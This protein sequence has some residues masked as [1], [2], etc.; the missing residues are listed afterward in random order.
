MK[1][2]KWSEP[3]R[4]ELVVAILIAIVSLTTA[5]ATWRTASVGSNAVS[6]NHRGLISAVKKEAAMNEDWRQAYQEAGYARDWA[7]ALTGIQALENS[8]DV[9]AIERAGVMRQFLL[10]GLASLAGPFA[11]D[12][13]YRKADG[14]FDVEKRFNSLEAESP[15][16]SSLD[17]Q[18]SFKQAANYF[19]EQRWLVIGTVLMAISL[20]WLGV[21]QIARPRLRPLA[22]LAGVGIYVFGAAWFILVEVVFL[23]IRKGSL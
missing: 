16:L 1:K 19:N 21:A 22:R 18:A 9:A 4:L 15:D 11:S 5:L 2:S 14:S 7:I 6:A 10:P 8:G 13:S 20:F 17:P 3:G 12:T 23:I